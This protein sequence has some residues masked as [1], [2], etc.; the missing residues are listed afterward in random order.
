VFKENK[1]T[2]DVETVSSTSADSSKAPLVQLNKLEMAELLFEKLKEVKPV[3]VEHKA[4]TLEDAR[5]FLAQFKQYKA[6][7]DKF[8]LNAPKNA[9]S[10]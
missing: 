3:R 8:F 2:I 5:V 4:P 10:R 7:D 6:A 1:K 9:V